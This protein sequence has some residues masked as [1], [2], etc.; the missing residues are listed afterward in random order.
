MSGT[1]AHTSE[2]SGDL[3]TFLRTQQQRIV[4]EWL[5]ATRV[6]PRVARLR[7]PR[8][9]G[10]VPL[11]LDQIA[12]A[13][14][15][16]A[17]GQAPQLA[18]DVGDRHA[19]D[20]LRHG[21]ELSEVVIELSLLRDC[22]LRLWPGMSAAPAQIRAQTLV[23]VQE[24]DRVIAVAVARYRD[25]RDHALRDLDSV[26]SAAVGEMSLDELLQKLATAFREEMP[27]VEAVAIWL[28]DG[29]LL[30]VRAG[31][32]AEEEAAIGVSLPIG[33]GFAGTVAAEQRPIQLSSA[34][35][36][37]LVQRGGIRPGRIDAL[38]GLPLIDGGEVLG[39][40]HMGSLTAHEFSVGDRLLFSSMASRVTAGITQHRLRDRAERRARELEESE[41]RFRAT[42]ENAAVGIAHLALDGTWLRLNRNFCDILGY[43]QDELMRLRF[44]D[45]T[46][47]DD[48][49]QDFGEINRLLAGEAEGVTMEKRFVRKDGR[50]IW[51]RSAGSLVRGVSGEPDYLVAVVHDITAQRSLRDRLAFLSRASEILG[52]TLDL[53]QTLDQVARL[54]IPVLADWCTVDIVGPDGTL[55]EFVAIVHRDPGKVEQVQNL[56]RRHSPGLPDFGPVQVMRTGQIG[57]FSEVD[58]TLLRQMSADEHALGTLRQLQLAALLFVP[59]IHGDRVLGSLS[60]AMAE[61]RRTFG[62]EDVELAQELARRA[63]AAIDNARLHEQSERA[64]RM[65][66]Q[67]LAIVSHDLRSPLG[68]VAMSSGLLVKNPAIRDQPA[69][70]RHVETIQRSAGRAARL[71]GDLLDIASIQ[72][73]KLAIELSSCRVDSLVSDCIEAYEPMARQKGI[74]LSGEFELEG[75]ELPCDHDRIAQVLSNLVGNAIKFCSP[76][77]RVTVRA[78]ARAGDVQ[79]SIADTGPGIPLDEIEHIFEV[80]WKGSGRGRGTGLGLFIAR[81]IIEAHGGRIWAESQAGKGSTFSF[82]LPR[83]STD[84]QASG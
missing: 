26:S 62:S 5:A 31:A 4:A 72:T 84:P 29:D 42:F 54:A 25:A 23:V 49:A 14:D 73:G 37:P 50:I 11:V 43:T 57:L 51:V 79:V 9:A 45:I 52:S 28:R 61:S 1:G 83:S 55:G 58:E 39:V 10:F 12:G 75:N 44:Q 20:R 70:R 38:Y 16:H 40:A 24:V 69:T 46:Y 19:M 71:I 41:R 2:A 80:Y 74:E 82:T 67:I 30:T 17:A 34:A 53:Q 48:L 64:V 35:T 60:L 15:Q 7:H 63:S 81:S 33:Q 77:D 18:P 56:R 66:E 47:P 13:L 27:C 65:R 3:A 76:R 78:Q 32:G 21:F 6:L 59:L 36:N 8:L 68:T 22:I